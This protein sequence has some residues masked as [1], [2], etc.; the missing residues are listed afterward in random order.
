MLQSDSLVLKGQITVETV[1]LDGT[2][3]R[4]YQGPNLIVN[5]GLS[6]MVELLAQLNTQ[7]APAN[8][9]IGSIWVG[10]RAT[11][12][13]STAALTPVAAAQTT[14]QGLVISRLAT[15][16]LVVLA[17]PLYG[18]DVKTTLGFTD[19]NGNDLQEMGMYTYGT[20][21]DPLASSTATPPSRMIA[22]QVFGTLAKTASIAVDFTWRITLAAS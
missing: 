19:G 3:T 13:G 14:L 4:I 15:T 1:S 21:A 8:N 11:G 12:S 5:Q 9:K 17:P 2:R 16:S 20:L 18:L 7:Q 10:G 6:A 22:R